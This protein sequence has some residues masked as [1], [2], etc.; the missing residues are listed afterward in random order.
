[1]A[2]NQERYYNINKLN[3]IFAFVSILLLAAL[4][5][6]FVDDYKREWKDHQKKF[7]ELEIEKTRQ[8][9]ADE[10]AKLGDN[11]Q[12]QSLLKDLDAAKTQHKEKSGEI[13]SE[14]SK[15]SQLTTK[16]D[17]EKQKYQFKKAEFDAAKYAFENASSHNSS[18][19][20]HLKTQLEKVEQETNVLFKLTEELNAGVVAQQGVMDQQTRQL[21]DMEKKRDSLARQANILARKLNLI[22]PQ[23]MSFANKIANF[24]RDLPVLDFMNPNYRIQQV[25]LKD[26]TEDVN[27]A[28]IP[29]VDRCMTCHL[30]IAN[31]DFK[32]APQPFTTHP[33]LELYLTSKSPHP[34][35]EFG[36][37]VCH[38]GRGRGTDFYSAVHTPS[39][40][41]Q[42]KEWEQKKG[43]KKYELWEAPMYSK[44]HIQAGC[45]KCHSDQ[46]VIKGAERLNIGLNLIEKSGCY[47]CH[48]IE[49]YTDWVKVGPDL[50]FISSKLTPQWAYRW[51]EDP[52]SFRHNTWMPA[53]F[54][55]SNTND[56]ESKKRGQQEIHS[57]VHYLFAKS[58]EFSLSDVAVSADAKK[59]EELVSSLGCFGC[60]QIEPKPVSKTMTLQS[61]RREHGPNLI[62]MGS[63]SSKKWLFDWLKNPK[64]Y[65]PQTRMPNLR[66]SDEEAANITEYLSA[67]KN[68][69]FMNVKVPEI[70]PVILNEIVKDFLKKENTSAQMEEKLTK[71]NSEEKLQF[72]GEKL[73]R[74]YGCFGC[75]TIPG[76]ENEKPIGTDLTEEGSKSA[77]RLDFGFV[78]MEHSPQAWFEQKLK[79]PRIF[80]QNRIKTPDEKLKMPNFCFTEDQAKAITTALLGFVKDK[81]E[82]S[83]LPKKTMRRQMVNSGQRLVREFNCQ[84]CHVIEGDGSAIGPSIH[85]W[86]VKY[87]N[88]SDAEAEALIKSFGPPDLI[89]EG[90]KVHAEWLFN[91]IHSPEVIRPWL[92]VRMPSFGLSAKENND[93]VK[94]FNALD[95]QDFPFTQRSVGEITEDERKAAEILFS[96][97]Y[98]DCTSCHIVGD[99]MPSGTPDKWAPDFAL[100]KTRLKPEWIAQWIKDPQSLLPGTKMPTYFDPKYFDQSGPDDVLGGDENKQIHVLRDYILTL[101]GQPSSESKADQPSVQQ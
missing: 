74:H 30:G 77:H 91:F 100:A 83:K 97:N 6:L 82:E 99:K 56:P 95:D 86:L 66:L 27:F 37:T 61:L 59:G 54:D 76:F 29:K 55:Q 64:R 38:Q 44:E 18:D 73:I 67:D 81:P 9:Y 46:T 40:L 85:D 32:D 13:A 28:H 5:F 79:D 58:S 24:I 23:K 34:F 98:F 69:D 89:G 48:Y 49:R 26:I 45:Y 31:P 35:E 60:H 57:I 80:D 21:R 33:N 50:T 94:Y 2:D 88:K 87:Q 52:K 4:V 25:V 93:F 65:H 72:A 8:R 42:Q 20:T 12:Y 51:I 90:K 75:H 43:W 70:D 47:G 63:K 96:K 41:E 39:S 19:V 15:F 16:Y 53:F 14:Q 1:M 3:K 71:M 68:N 84:G 17:I 22:D 7:R 62:G 92:T 10:S 78:H 11:A 101:T 36:C